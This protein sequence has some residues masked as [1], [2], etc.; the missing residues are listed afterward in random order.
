MKYN[1]EKIRVMYN[2]YIAKRALY[3]FNNFLK[4]SQLLLPP[5]VDTQSVRS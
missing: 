3:A 5:I 4:M 1:K 2:K